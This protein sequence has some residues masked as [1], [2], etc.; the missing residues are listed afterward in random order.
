[1]AVTNQRAI[2][3]HDQEEGHDDGYDRWDGTFQSRQYIIGEYAE[4][5][6]PIGH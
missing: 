4:D 2:Y 5:D 6:G 1:M 3:G